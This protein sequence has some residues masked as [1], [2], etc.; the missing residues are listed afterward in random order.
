[1]GAGGGGGA[2]N[3]QTGPILVHIY[4]PF[5]NNLHV[6]YRSNLI[7]TFWVKIKNMKKI[8][9]GSCWALTSNPGVPRAPKC[10]Q[11]QTS[12]QWR[13][14]YNKGKQF[15]NHFFIYGPK[16]KKN[17]YFGGILG[18]LRG[19]SMIRLN[20]SCFPAIVSPI[21]MYMR[22]KEAIW[23]DIFKFKPKI[24]K[25]NTFFHIWGVLGGPYVEPRWTEISGQ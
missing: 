19:S 20:L 4:P 23:K 12:S 6:K 8:F 21:S 1:M 18:A 2:F 16:C 24:W 13:H 3:N 14:M 5:N 25:N 22:N 15:E 11:T 9:S 17:V 10:Q 7:R